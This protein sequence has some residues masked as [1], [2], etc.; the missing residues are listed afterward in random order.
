MNN[1]SR[2]TTSLLL[3]LLTLI[4]GIA[5]GWLLRDALRGS[6]TQNPLSPTVRPTTSANALEPTQP[7]VV[8]TAPAPPTITLPSPLPTIAPSPPPPATAAPEPSPTRG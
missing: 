1:Q 7:A 6:P 8:A 5:L 2:P 3:I 4:T